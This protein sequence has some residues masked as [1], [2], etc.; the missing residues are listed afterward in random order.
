M[1][2]NIQT[3]GKLKLYITCYSEIVYTLNTKED[4]TIQLGKNIP[5]NIN[6]QLPIL[7]VKIR[8]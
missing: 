1:H 7:K 5:I 2:L 3:L 8:N 4:P 6:D